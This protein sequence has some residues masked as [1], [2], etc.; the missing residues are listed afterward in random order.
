M[1]NIKQNYAKVSQK[2]DFVRMATNADLRMEDKNSLIKWLH[3]KNTNKKNACHFLKAS[4]AVTVLDVI[5]DMKKEKST[6]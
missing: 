2:L 5:L 6:K 3:A 1:Q 4:I